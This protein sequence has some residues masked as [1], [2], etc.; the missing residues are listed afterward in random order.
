MTQQQ[1]E[2]A[3]HEKASD[4]TH[5]EGLAL[6]HKVGRPT[7]AQAKAKRIAEIK[8]QL[9]R[10]RAEEIETATFLRDFR[11][12]NKVLYFGLFEGE[13]NPNKT[14]RWPKQN[15]KQEKLLAAFREPVY[16][17]FT[18]TGSNRCGKTAVWA[19]IVPCYCAKK[20]LWDDEPIDFPHG[21]PRKIRVVGQDWEKHIATVVVPAMKEWWPKSRMVLTQ[22]NN[23]GVEAMWT[24]EET[25]S[26]VEIMS[27]RQDPELFE[28][29]HGD[30][31]I[32][33]EPPRRDIHI[34]CARGL[35]DRGGRELFCA[36]LLKEAWID[37]E[38]IKAMGPDG[39][40]DRTV[41][42]VHATIMDN[43]GFGITLE[44]VQQFEKLLTED[45]KQARIFGVPSYMS[46][47]VYPQ[48][49]RKYRPEGHLVEP[50][51]VP[52]SWIV[53]IAI[54]VHPRKRQAVLFIATSEKN[55]RYVVDEVWEH[56]D[57]NWLAEEIVRRVRTN[58]YRVNRI[59]IDPLAK[60]DSNSE[61]T[62]Y[63]KVQAVLARHDLLLETAS[64]DKD[65]GIIAVKSHLK[66]PNNEPSLFVF[67]S[68]TRF[69][70]EIEG[71]MYEDKGENMGK[72]S[73]EDDDMMEN[74]YRLCLL[75]TEYISPDQDDWFVDEDHGQQYATM[76]RMAGY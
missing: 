23:M 24:D 15:R 12:D 25:G 67:D 2:F 65:S 51:A 16:K 61:N 38:V 69:I 35:I 31:I 33:D 21:K 34:A 54:D 57:G 13:I 52:T 30:L 1:R 45:E 14:L 62:T 22:K 66:G 8:E 46:G 71:Y 63:D 53:D 28:G 10:I 49:S 19:A 48:F 5:E 36:T 59:V 47:L 73:K 18:Y 60:G 26:T 43:V 68:C 32:Y 9:K 58:A 41:Y 27:N 29:W 64:K 44:N 72:P 40:P 20:W 6:K 39:K 50:F 17:T 42:T 7:D 74:L 3:N 76:D 11:D 70:A 37:R 4:F 55:E 75:D 56:G